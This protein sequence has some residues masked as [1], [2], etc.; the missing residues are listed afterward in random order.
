MPGSRRREEWGVI[1]GDGVSGSEDEKVLQM[2]GWG[3]LPNSV[4]VYVLTTF[5]NN[6][7]E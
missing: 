4:N 1:R 6:Y 5:K 2:A 7:D 3:Q